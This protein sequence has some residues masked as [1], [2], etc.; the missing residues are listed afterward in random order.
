MFPWCCKSDLRKKFLHHP[1]HQKLKAWTTTE[2]ETL[3]F[4]MMS[5]WN[6]KL[7]VSCFLGKQ[8]GYPNR[9]ACL[10][11]QLSRRDTKTQLKQ[12]CQ[13]LKPSEGLQPGSLRG[14]SGKSVCTQT[15]VRYTVFMSLSQAPAVYFPLTSENTWPWT[16][17]TTACFMSGRHAL[18]LCLL[19]SSIKQCYIRARPA[20]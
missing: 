9:C 16:A 5:G 6:S 17:A 18:Y 15:P 1:E 20:G 12:V 8:I 3:T 2:E 10:T 11:K 4:T 14:L 19:E 13:A 7:I